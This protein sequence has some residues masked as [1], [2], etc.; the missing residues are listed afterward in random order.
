M[1]VDSAPLLVIRRPRPTGSRRPGKPWLVGANHYANVIEQAFA[2]HLGELRIVTRA[3]KPSQFLTAWSR[4]PPVGV[5][6]PSGGLRQGTTARVSLPWVS[7][8]CWCLG[9][10]ARIVARADLRH[11]PTP[12][13]R[14][15]RPRSERDR[16]AR[17]LLGEWPRSAPIEPTM[18]WSCPFH[19]LPHPRCPRPGRIGA[20]DDGQDRL[21]APDPYAEAVAVRISCTKWP[22]GGAW[23]RRPGRRRRAAV[24][25]GGVMS[26][27]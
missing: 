3:L 20:V 25:P 5:G 13:P 19:L 6:T 9:R 7:G 18:P 22:I 26:A 2:G 17:C 16:P 4:P 10:P 8:P 14:H 24:R 27:G 15:H 23:R 1:Y 12:P 21:C 11:S